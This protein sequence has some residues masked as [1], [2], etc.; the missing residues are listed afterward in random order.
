MFQRLTSLLLSVILLACPFFCRVGD[1]CAHDYAISDTAVDTTTESCCHH[2]DDDSAAAAS[3]ADGRI[4]NSPS[5]HQPLER[6]ADP[7]LCNGAVL[8][9][10]DSTAAVSHTWL[11]PTSRLVGHLLF[12]A[13]V[14]RHVLANGP[15]PSSGREIRHARMSLLI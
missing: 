6:C 9:A 14:E 1:C 12:R 10:A 7:C 13:D 4:P 3:E 8:N 5:P 15:P 2:C 11:S